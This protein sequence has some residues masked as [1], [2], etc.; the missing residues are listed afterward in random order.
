MRLGD[1]LMTT[2]RRTLLQPLTKQ[3][4]ADLDRAQATLKDVATALIIAK[5]AGIDVEHLEAQAKA[6]QEAIMRMKRAYGQTV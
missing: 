6:Q 4:I 2:P 3:D 5:Q 1:K